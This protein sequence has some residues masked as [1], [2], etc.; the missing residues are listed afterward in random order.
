MYETFVFV[1]WIGVL[2]GFAVAAF[3]KQGY[4][5]FIAAFM[6][7]LFLSLATRFS[8]GGDTMGMLAP[9]LNSNFWLSLHIITIATGYAGCLAAGVLGHGALLRQGF[10]AIMSEDPAGQDREN[11]KR[12]M[13]AL[14]A[15]GFT[16]T[17]IG[18]VL[19]GMWAEQAWGRFWGW[20][21]KENGALL[22]ILWCAILFHARRAG[23]LRRYAGA[24]GIAFCVPL[25]MLAWVGV[26]L[27]GIGMHSYGFTAGG[28]QILFW[29]VGSDAA[30]LA[31]LAGRLLYLQSQ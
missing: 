13:W 19:G 2:L 31:V 5:L 4:G 6:G 8:A 24:F 11:L 25:V 14:L 21:P 7:I 20:D 9:V 29:I 22:I 28:A 27:L 15:A 10:P 1:A 17:T 18:T 30:L 16:G 23:L 26:N 3:Q 12:A